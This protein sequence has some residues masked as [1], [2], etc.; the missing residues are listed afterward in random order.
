MLDSMVGY[1]D[2]MKCRQVFI[3]VDEVMQFLNEEQQ[4]DIWEVKEKLLLECEY[5]IWQEEKLRVDRDAL[6][7]LLE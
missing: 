6:N 2:G 1:V 4:N 7:D 3:A 5:K